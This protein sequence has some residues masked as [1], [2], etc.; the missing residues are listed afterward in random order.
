MAIS[1]TLDLDASRRAYWLETITTGGNL[2]NQDLEK[3]FLQN[4]TATTNLS[5][6]DMRK[7][8]WNTTAGTSGLSTQDAKW[9]ATA[10]Y[11]HSELL[12]L[13]AQP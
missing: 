6:Q 1:Q 3:S 7:I 11:N 9:V 8:Y 13:R 4:K 12:W 10:N 5:V 2:S